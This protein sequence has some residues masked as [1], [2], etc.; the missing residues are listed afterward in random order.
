MNNT[1]V[2]L[3]FMGAFLSR[4]EAEIFREEFENGFGQDIK[5]GNLVVIQD[6]IVLINNHWVVR[7]MAQ[8]SQHELDLE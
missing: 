8:N 1:Q 3:C 5:D 6:D 7:V 2:R 4:D